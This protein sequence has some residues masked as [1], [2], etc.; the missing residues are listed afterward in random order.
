M[1]KEINSPEDNK[2]IIELIASTVA[3]QQKFNINTPITIS[4]DI[5]SMPVI[6][7]YLVEHNLVDRVTLQD[8][9]DEK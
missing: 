9:T 3:L 4:C 7:Q 1:M 8:L 2:A 6:H 5:E